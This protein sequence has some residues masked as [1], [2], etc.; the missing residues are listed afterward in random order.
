MMD[1]KA[2][3]GWGKHHHHGP[4]GGYDLMQKGKEIIERMRENGM[5]ELGKVSFIILLF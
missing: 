5:L 4:H 2:K 3:M 1:W